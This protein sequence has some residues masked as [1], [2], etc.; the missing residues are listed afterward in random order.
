MAP[1]SRRRPGSLP[2]W[3]WLPPTRQVARRRPTWTISG[4]S[5]GRPFTSNM[6]RTAVSFDA[7]AA[8][9][10]TVSVGIATRPPARSTSTAV[11][12]SSHNGTASRKS[13]A[14]S[15]NPN[16]SGVGEVVDVA[17]R[18]SVAFGNASTS[19]SPGPAKSRRR[20]RRASGTSLLPGVGKYRSTG[21][22]HHC[23]ECGD[24]VPGWLA[25]WTNIR[26]R[27]SSGSP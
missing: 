8:S 23:R 22:P 9:P 11:S 20:S 21:S 25:Y 3:G 7:S 24:V 2:T 16:D 4:W 17:Q 6:R 5:I 14:A 1:A 19:G 26:D 10:Y 13:R 15:M 27:L 18:R 12:M